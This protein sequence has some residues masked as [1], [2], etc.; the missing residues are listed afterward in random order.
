MGIRLLGLTCLLGLTTVTAADDSPVVPA[1]PVPPKIELRTAEVSV[2][3]EKVIRPDLG[4]IADEASW[5]ISHASGEV[6][7]SGGRQAVR[8]KAKGD[9]AQGI[10][11]LAIP[12]GVAF[13]TGSIEID[14]KGRSVRPSFVGIAFNVVDEKTFEAVYF[15]P[16]NFKA[17]GAFKGR[18][19]QYVAW[20]EHPWD[21]LRKDRPGRFEGPIR[22]A[23]DP[24][25]WFRV[26]I[27][28]SEKQVRVFVNEA[29]KSCLKVDR[30]AGGEKARPVGLF[31]D[32]AD[33][34]YRK[35]KITPAR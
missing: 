19:V 21:R 7:Q 32:T 26:R 28:V 23:P 35:L 3:P 12:G 2:P 4:K 9:S 20:P 11:G 6:V 27:E 17:A 14:L 22:P 33:G 8:L 18:A 13:A 15:R 31:V 34:L 25:G 16:F 24:D 10:V 1:K 30:L 5:T 29:K